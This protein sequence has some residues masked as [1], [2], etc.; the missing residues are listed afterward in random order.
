M[1]AQS[2]SRGELR[3]MLKNLTIGQLLKETSTAFKNHP[4]TIY[5]Q[6]NIHY[7]YNELYNETG[8]VA[9]ALL[10]LGIK[11][12]DHIAVWST[13]RL[14]WILLQL[15]SARIGAVLV[16]VNTSYQEAEVE[17]LLNHSDTTALFYIDSFKTTSYS[18]IIASIVHKLPR[19]QHL[20]SIDNKNQKMNWNQF[21]LYSM[22]ISDEALTLAEQNVYPEEVINMQY[23]SG[24]TGFPKGVM[25]SHNNIPEL[26]IAN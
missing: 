1:K 21:L 15:A 20:I 23:T 10:G 9:K 7:T 2:L 12:G 17:Y 24:T 4:A 5:S 22:N 19:L 3:L 8:K 11:K 25:L 18:S 14:E 6:E 26:F 13:N 16:T